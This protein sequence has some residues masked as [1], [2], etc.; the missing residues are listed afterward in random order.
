VNGTNIF[1]TALVRQRGDGEFVCVARTRDQ[2]HGSVLCPMNGIRS[3]K[4]EIENENVKAPPPWI[5]RTSCVG[6]RDR[7]EID[8][9]EV[10]DRL[11]PAVDEEVKIVPRQAGYGAARTADVDRHFHKLDRVFFASLRK[12]WKSNQDDEPTRDRFHRRSET[13]LE[14]RSEQYFVTAPRFSTTITTIRVLSR[15]SGILSSRAS[16]GTPLRR[17]LTIS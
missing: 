3:R 9:I 8:D 14:L 10:V 1:Q 16:R 15:G 7:A 17:Q 4:H 12:E 2:L 6:R 5:A 11:R 13:T